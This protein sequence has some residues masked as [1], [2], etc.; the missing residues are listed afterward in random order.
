MV[1]DKNTEPDNGYTLVGLIIAISF[2]LVATMVAVPLWSTAIK[3]EKE[4][5]LIFR[6]MQYAIAIEEYK[7]KTGKDLLD[8]E[9]LI[10]TKP[11]VIRKL[12][13]DPMTGKV[14]WRLIHRGEIMIQRRR[15][16]A[17]LNSNDKNEK[18]G[19]DLTAPPDIGGMGGPIIGVA[20]TCEDES[21]RIYQDKNRY[22]EW[23]FT[24]NELKVKR[25][26][27]LGASQPGGVPPPSPPSGQKPGTGGI[28]EGRG[29]GN[30][31]I[32]GK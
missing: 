20:S 29:P 31:K 13:T 25:A 12:W 19:S 14:D 26:L 3:R 27:V 5:E 18:S 6:G 2:L 11:R 28:S 8:L 15:E 17:G 23:L 32:I 22:S 24:V 1:K 7:M 9:S 21:I 10:K 4:K 30:V 16:I